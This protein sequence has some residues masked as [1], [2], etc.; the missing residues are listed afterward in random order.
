MKKCIR[1]VCRKLIILILNDFNS[2]ES[3]DEKHP[4]LEEYVRKVVLHRFEDA[5]FY[6]LPNTINC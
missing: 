2:C 1:I 4:I 6:I 3:N 5:Q